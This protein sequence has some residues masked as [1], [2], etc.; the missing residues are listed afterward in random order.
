MSRVETIDE[1]TL[2]L[3]GATASSTMPTGPHCAPMPT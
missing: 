3:S 1:A 2:Y